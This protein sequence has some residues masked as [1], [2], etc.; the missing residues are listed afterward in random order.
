MSAHRAR[1]PSRV[2]RCHTA[3]VHHSP[4]ARI[5]SHFGDIDRTLSGLPQQHTVNAVSR[6]L[7]VGRHQPWK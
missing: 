5:L 6:G 3:S 1:V 2:T 4:E 7:A